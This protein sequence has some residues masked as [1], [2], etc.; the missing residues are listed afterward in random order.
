MIR[1]YK[2][3]FL[4]NKTIGMRRCRQMGI[5]LLLYRRN[6]NITN[7]VERFLVMRTFENE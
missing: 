6:K 1:T 3:M 4:L 7:K 2:V 5:Q